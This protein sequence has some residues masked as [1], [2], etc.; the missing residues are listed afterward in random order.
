MKQKHNF[1]KFIPF[2][3][4]A[5]KYYTEHIIQIVLQLSSS[6]AGHKSL[7]WQLNKFWNVTKCFKEGKD[8]EVGRRTKRTGR[9]AKPG[10]SEYALSPPFGFLLTPILWSPC[11]N[12]DYNTRN[13]T[14]STH[15]VKVK[16]KIPVPLS[17][18]DVCQFRSKKYPLSD[19]KKQRYYF[20]K[21][22]ST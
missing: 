18:S 1:L 4:L 15:M 12:D 13:I 19:V 22:L 9:R 3:R 17:S 16:L 6:A 8:S 14:V 2:I 21:K 11:F 20:S 10:I 7:T 5:I